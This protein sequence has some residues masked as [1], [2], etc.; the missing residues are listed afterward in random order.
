MATTRTKLL[1]ILAS[2]LLEDTL[3]AEI[4]SLGATGCSITSARGHGM[5]GARPDAWQGGNVRIE[6]LASG[7]VVSRILSRLEQH[8]LAA[9]PMVVWVADVD[10]WPAAH[11]ADK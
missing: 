6:V 3:V 9:N 4:L 7:A 8:Y 10:A 11:F 1:T 5:H 2:D